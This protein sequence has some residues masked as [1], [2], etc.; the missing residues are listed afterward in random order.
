MVQPLWVDHETRTSDYTICQS[1]TSLKQPAAWMLTTTISMFSKLMSLNNSSTLAAETAWSKCGRV[2]SKICTLQQ[3][4]KVM[5]R[6]AQS[7][8]S[9]TWMPA[10]EARPLLAGPT[11]N[12]SDFT[13]WQTSRQWW[14]Q[15]PINPM[16]SMLQQQIRATWKCLMRRRLDNSTNSLLLLR[17]TTT[18][19]PRSLANFKN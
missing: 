1:N 9:A 16:S 12:Q 13:E 10:M 11:T 15:L 19:Q 18:L 6:T 4:W 17:A 3:T 7:T 8:R 5:P 14:R 2:S